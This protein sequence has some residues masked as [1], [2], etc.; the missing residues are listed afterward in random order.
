MQ[1]QTVHVCVL[2]WRGTCSAEFHRVLLSSA[3]MKLPKE[4]KN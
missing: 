3:R 2:I 1:V 4:K